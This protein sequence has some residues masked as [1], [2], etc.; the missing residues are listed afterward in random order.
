MKS[1]GLKSGLPIWSFSSV[2]N[3]LWPLI[4]V[5]EIQ[6]L[7]NEQLE[8]QGEEQAAEV[9]ADEQQNEEAE[10]PGEMFNEVHNC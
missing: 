1:R 10:V 2:V 5:A 3:R 9:P 7:L 6:R 4:W 8:D